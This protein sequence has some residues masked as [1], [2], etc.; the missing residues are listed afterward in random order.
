MSDMAASSLSSHVT[1]ESL[2]IS[3][4]TAHWVAIKRDGSKQP[5]DH[6]KIIQA[7]TRCFV[8]QMHM[9]FPEA[10]EKAKEIA[11]G[12]VNLLGIDVSS[13]F[14]IET[15]QDAVI[16]TLWV[17]GQHAA[18]TQYTLYRE[19]RRKE[20][21]SRPIDPEVL[22][23]VAEDR[24]ILKTPAQYYQ[25]VSKFARWK[26]QLKRRETWTEAI[27]RVFDWFGT[28]PHYGKLTDAE[29]AW[30]H[31]MMFTMKASS[32]LRVLQMAGPALERC[33]MGVYNC[34]GRETAFVTREGV[35]TFEDFADGDRVEVLSHTGCWRNAV[36]RNYGMQTLRTRVIRRGSSE[37]RVRATDFHRWI[38]KD[39]TVTD[40]LRV[41]DMLHQ[42]PCPASGWDYNDAEPDEKLFWAYGFVYGDG[43]LIKRAG[44]YTSSMVRLCGDKS[45]FLERFEELGFSHSF[46][47]SHEGDPMV[48]TGHYLKALPDLA[49][50][51]VR[52]VLAFVRGWLDADG[53]KQVGQGNAN[54]Y[55]SIQVTGEEG[56]NFVRRVFPAVG[57]YITREDEV[58][59]ET[60][61]GTRSATT[62]RFGL[63]NRFGSAPN[64]YHSLR[65]VLSDDS[66]E[67]VWCLE[68]EEDHSFVLPCGVVTGNCAALPIKDLFAFSEF[69]YVLMQGSGCGFSVENFYVKRLPVVKKQKKSPK[70]K[71]VVADTTEGWCDALYYCMQ[72]WFG[73]Y[74]VD[75][76]TSKVRPAGTRLETKGGLASGPE[77][78]ID[79]LAFARKIVLSAQGRKLTDLEC[80]DIC[81]K[82]AKI[83]QV[84]GVRRAST[85]SISDL[86]SPA[87][88]K[89]K[90]GEWWIEHQHRAMANNSTAY[91]KQ[92]DI[93]T[94]MAE[95][96]ALVDSQS[97]ERGIFNRQAADRLR[98]KRRKKAR[99]LVNPCV[100]ADTWVLT[101]E[102][103]KQVRDLLNSPFTAVVD[104]D[105]HLSPTGFVYTGHKAVKQV[106]LLNGFTF[107]ATGN[108]QVLVVRHQTKTKQ[109][110]EWV[111]VDDLQVG[112]KVV[113]HDH[114]GTSFAGNG[115]ETE[116]WL[117][118]NLLGDGTFSHKQAYL[119]YWG[120]N[121]RDMMKLAV[122][123]IHETVGGRAHLTGHTGAV[124]CRVQSRQLYKLAESYG[125]RDKLVGPAIE[126][127]SSAFHAGF[128]RGWFDADGS[129]QGTQDKGISVRLSSA[130]LSNLQA[131][132]RMLARLG[133][134]STIYT[135]RHKAGLQEMPDGRGGT[136]TYERQSLHELVISKENLA[137]FSQVV[138]FD[139][140]NKQARLLLLLNGYR[141]KLNREPFCAEV[142][143]IEAVGTEDVFDCTVPGPAAFDANGCYVHNCA[144]IIFRPF[145][146]CNLS[147]AVAREDDTEETLTEKVRAAAYFGK[148]QSLCTKFKY[149]RD[150]WRVNA[151][152]ER[153][154]GVD[155]T[156]HAD[157]PLLQYG[158]PG[159]AEL[160]QRL[161][162]EV[163]KVDE[164]LSFRFGCG[165]SAA[166]TTVKPA[167][168]ASELFACAS[169]ASPR[170]AEF[171]I[172]R[173]RESK[174]SPVADFL[175]ASGVPHETAMEDDG[176]WAFAMPKKAPE[177]STLRD[178]M[179]A[180][181]Q[182]H[183]W[184]EWK[185]NWAE[186]SVS[187]TIYVKDHEWPEVQYLVWK[188][189]NEITC[190]SFLP[191]DNGS[192]RTVPNEALTEAEYLKFEKEFP[193]LQWGKLSQYEKEDGTHFNRAVACMGDSCAL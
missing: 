39:G 46:P 62:V 68:V 117:L 121:R 94:F 132:Q 133:I 145:G 21:E 179:S 72:Q 60:N 75:V 187:V 17:H 28:L 48:Y 127:T 83:V 131:A 111:E 157:C 2:N 96:K 134:V 58:V 12:T 154:L 91:N 73:G 18:A 114:R 130:S 90:H 42:P 118:G 169:G 97:G 188:H 54:E 95:F 148:I 36:V 161:K 164:E 51:G 67:E 138:G 79:L 166:N 167:G 86:D 159:R 192:Y 29:K 191:W 31:D 71:Y 77:P 124:T 182:I 128:L 190:L 122:S 112:D 175:I 32:S 33:H 137:T 1:A 173:F 15:I 30:L 120:E 26:P 69:L 116:G 144:E 105:K 126:K 125:L 84:G 141:R 140:A 178:D 142:Q 184:L 168:D 180:A 189:F 45:R 171:Q 49:T 47:P 56:I 158:A 89:A 93:Y 101:D 6:N 92:P 5:F 80:H 55:A 43:T 7:V 4:I 22:R 87:M 16:R 85:I 34:L 165:R 20:R 74:D 59:T 40:D 106:N 109:R 104:G 162:A 156:G 35:K 147:I 8:N 99:W 153:L 129:V 150:E 119:D 61:Y 113:L 139:D 107:K 160:L 174:I 123:R 177:G 170:F 41:G 136:Q 152:D 149:V 25:F 193:E 183:N 13:D 151:E 135:D 63:V 100:P 27:D 52:K 143:S 186:H 44:K 88:R 70:K 9:G 10:T 108:H 181:D 37:C 176:L 3:E 155:I 57:F 24:K 110:T 38:C 11:R 172:R 65:E 102:G 76:D 185:R 66:V 81:C 103:P 50:D 98:P 115:S 163:A 23:L 146:L 53:H 19:E 78:L 82:E 64:S 14:P